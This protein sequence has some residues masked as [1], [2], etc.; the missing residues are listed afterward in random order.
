VTASGRLEAGCTARCSRLLGPRGRQI[1]FR[2]T[3][4][5][6]T[7]VL[8]ASLSNLGLIVSLLG[9]VN[10]S[11]IA[12]VLPPMFDLRPGPGQPSF[13]T[14]ANFGTIALGLLGRI[15]GTFSVLHAM[16]TGGGQPTH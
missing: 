8:A 9:S 4:V 11:L 1:V 2:T 3:L 6:C 5:L 12:L 13:D 15:A 7:A 16:S 10:C 14:A